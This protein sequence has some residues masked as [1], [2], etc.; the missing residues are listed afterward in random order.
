MN[1]PTNALG[2]KL[3]HCVVAVSD[4]ERSDAFYRDVLGFPVLFEA[5]GMTFMRAG[6]TS[7]MIGATPD[8]KPPS[9]DVIVPLVT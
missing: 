5:G 7:L 2:L 9:G 8:A 3:D 1:P 4:P 6:A